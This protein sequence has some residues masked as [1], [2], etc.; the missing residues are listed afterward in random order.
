MVL[1]VKNQTIL[2]GGGNPLPWACISISHLREQNNS[3]EVLVHGSLEHFTTLRWSYHE[4]L[5]WS[6][7][8]LLNFGGRMEGKVC[9]KASV[10]SVVCSSGFHP[11]F[12]DGNLEDQL[13]CRSDTF[14]I[15][16]NGMARDVWTSGNSCIVKMVSPTLN[17]MPWLVWSQTNCLTQSNLQERTED[18]GLV[19]GS[20]EIARVSLYLW[21]YK[22]RWISLWKHSSFLKVLF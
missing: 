2:G 21:I 19:C 14:S 12:V 8:R 10:S 16:G 11:S 22:T 3:T 15:C 7:C 9:E 20:R 17:W 1:L 6:G 4:W 18:A 13:W 5:R